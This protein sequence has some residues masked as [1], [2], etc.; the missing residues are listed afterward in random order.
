MNGR[1]A[2][3][4]ESITNALAIKRRMSIT[5]YGSYQPATEK[6]FLERQRD[7][8]R[9]N[10]YSRARLVS[11]EH[12]AGI[13]PLTSSKRHL[14]HSDVNFMFFT[15]NGMRQGIVRELA[16]VAED[17]AM[18]GKIADCV[19][20]DERDDARSSIPELSWSD[21]SSRRIEVHRFENER[22]LHVELL[23]R[24]GIFT[25]RKK[26]QIEARPFV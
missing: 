10:G 25:M 2:S 8:L 6:R 14:L 13:D 22:I 18:T 7:F 26:A 19:V 20:F 9:D 5:L 16:Y 11:D 21:I 4:V 17:P 23:A 12:I 1:R 24:A 15:K 3:T